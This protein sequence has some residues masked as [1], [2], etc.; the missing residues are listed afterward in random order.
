MIA[1]H[2]PQLE[3]AVAEAMKQLAGASGRARDEGAAAADVGQADQAAASLSGAPREETVHGEASGLPVAHHTDNTRLEAFSDA[4]FGFAATLLVVS[5]DVP[6]DFSMRCAQ[7]CVDSSSF[8]LSFAML[9]SIWA[10]HRGFFRRYPFGDTSIV[11]LNTVLMFLVLFYVYPL[12]FLSRMFVRMILGS[13]FVQDASGTTAEDL[14]KMFI[15]YGIGWAAVF[16]C[17]ALMYVHAGRLRVTNRLA[18]DGGRTARDFAGHFIIFGLAGLVSAAMAAY[19]IGARFGIPGFM[20][21]LLG[22]VLGLYW[23]WRHRLRE[24][25]A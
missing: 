7:I 11:I 6:I 10:V 24:R 17:V 19:G 18:A 5:L 1:G 22:P 3:R 16:G 21:A 9:A 14:G 20:Y 15:I 2:D 12:K 23:G 25:T 8:G 4:I 13:A